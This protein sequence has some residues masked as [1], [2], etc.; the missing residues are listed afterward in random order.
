MSYLYIY[1]LSLRTSRSVP[2]LTS[3]RISALLFIL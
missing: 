1:F 2:S 3:K